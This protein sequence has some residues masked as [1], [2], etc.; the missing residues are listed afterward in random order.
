M[1]CVSACLHHYPFLAAQHYDVLYSWAIEGLT[2][3]D[4]ACSQE[5]SRLLAL[6]SSD[7]SSW[8]RNVH[9][10]CHELNF[11]TTTAFAPVNNGGR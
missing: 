9:N 7:A 11:L 5:S 2:S 6:L 1:G 3:V 10:L 4:A 8:Q